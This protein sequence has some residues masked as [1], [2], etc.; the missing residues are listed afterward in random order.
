MDSFLTRN[1]YKYTAARARQGE[2]EEST[3]QPFLAGG[4]LPPTLV[5]GREKLR[6]LSSNIPD[7]ARMRSPARAGGNF[8]SNFEPSNIL[9]GRVLGSS[10]REELGR[11]EEKWHPVNRSP[12]SQSNTTRLTP[13]RQDGGRAMV[14]RATV[15][16]PAGER[17]DGRHQGLGK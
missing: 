17:A 5:G 8:S 2:G 16:R 1:D 9:H 4:K 11:L 10:E 15:V 13:D 7:G 12:F 14:V 3:R 6:F